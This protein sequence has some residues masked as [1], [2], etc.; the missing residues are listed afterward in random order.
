M[1][2]K[3]AMLVFA[4]RDPREV[5][6]EGQAADEQAA[7]A[8]ADEVFP[9]RVAGAIGTRELVEAVYPP[10]GTLY[11]G[12]FAGVDIVCCRELSAGSEDLEELVLRVGGQRN[13]VVHL[14]HSG[15]DALSFT[16]WVGGQ[17]RRSLSLAPDDG[18]VVDIGSHLEFELPYWAGEH[19]VGPSL[20]RSGEAEKPYALPFHPLDLGEEALRHFF[21]FAVE[22]RIDPTDID[23]FDVHLAGFNLTPTQAGIERAA[24]IRAAAAQMTRRSVMLS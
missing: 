15:V 8:L 16:S 11:A 14:M 6:R 21:G 5:F 22:G 23:P 3:T 2:A 13:A 24:A 1:G 7:R 4:E 9:G 19:S 20:F 17:V 10:E 12:R 18:I